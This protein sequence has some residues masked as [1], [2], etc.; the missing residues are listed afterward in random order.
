MK[1]AATPFTAFEKLTRAL[2]SVPKAEIDAKAK[3]YDRQ[4]SK[5][6]ATRKRRTSA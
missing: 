5:K 1:K 4:R 3:E 6:R 2:A